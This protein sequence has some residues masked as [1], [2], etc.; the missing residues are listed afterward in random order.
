MSIHCYTSL[1]QEPDFTENELI[2]DDLSIDDSTPGKINVK[3]STSHSSGIHADTEDRVNLQKPLTSPTPICASNWPLYHA[4]YGYIILVYFYSYS[5]TRL[6]TVDTEWWWSVQRNTQQSA[7]ISGRSFITSN[8]WQ[9][10]HT[11]QVNVTGTSTTFAYSLT[12]DAEKTL[13]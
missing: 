12:W 5:S 13:N 6:G 2:Y 9:N 4:P 7:G 8:W 3:F 10:R 11:P 1:L